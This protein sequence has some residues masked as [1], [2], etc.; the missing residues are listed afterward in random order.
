MADG[1]PP[2]HKKK[3]AA[4]GETVQE[5][6]TPSAGMS[7][8]MVRKAMQ[9]NPKLRGNRSTVDVLNEL[10]AAAGQ[11]PLTAAPAK[12]EAP[13][14]ATDVMQVVA[15]TKD[16][17]KSDMDRLLKDEQRILAEKKALTQR[18]LD[19]VIEI[20]I[21]VDPNL[22][23]PRTLMLLDDEKAFL[24]EIGFDVRK[25]VDKQKARK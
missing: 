24:R 18:S 8:E 6:A 23:S 5:S 21:S 15:Q 22:V 1:N 2:N 7:S 17:W 20:I 13:E 10:E 14:P 25:V 12:A 19:R 9:L 11:K 4:W 3:F 16:R